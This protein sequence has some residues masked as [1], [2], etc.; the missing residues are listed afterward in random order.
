MGK[1]IGKVRNPQENDDFSWDLMRVTLWYC[2]RQH[3]Y[4]NS[5]S[6]MLKLTIS[7]A[8]FNSYAKLPEGNG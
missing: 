7:M 3:S 6:L 2:K 1:A 4:E 5:Q 8:V